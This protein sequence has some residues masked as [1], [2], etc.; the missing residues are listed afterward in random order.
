MTYEEIASMIASVELPYAY[1]HFEVDEENPAPATPYIVFRYSP[2][3][4]FADNCN[5]V[6]IEHLI[7]ELRTDNKD[8]ETMAALEAAF[9][10]AGLTYTQTEEFD[11]VEVVYVETYEMDFVLKEE[12]DGG[13]SSS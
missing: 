9:L 8:Y 11:D 2:R 10:N 4:F 6:R 5:Y 3:P 7:V 13:D 12:T 1:D